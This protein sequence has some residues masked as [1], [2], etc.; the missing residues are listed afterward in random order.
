MKPR[1]SLGWASHHPGPVRTVQGDRIS[2]LGAPIKL[3]RH[4]SA[5]AKGPT[6]T[7]APRDDALRSLALGGMQDT[8]VN[9]GPFQF[10]EATTTS[11]A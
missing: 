6:R 9:S 4:L 10:L 11:H 8:A 1:E 2:S 7:K 5:E 3:S